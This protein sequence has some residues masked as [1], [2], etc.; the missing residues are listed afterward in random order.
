D[1][2]FTLNVTPSGGSAIASD[3]LKVSV[4]ATA[5]VP[6]LESDASGPVAPSTAVNLKWTIENFV[7]G[8]TAQVSADADPGDAT[9]TF[10]GQDVTPG[11]DGSGTLAVT[12]TKGGDFSF[13]LSVTPSGGTAVD[14]DP[15]KLTISGGTATAEW[16]VET[17]HLG[18]T[19]PM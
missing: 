12:P 16:G 6:H 18:D 8:M 10:G 2:N 17:V 7:A 13:K 5:P 15:L 9:F 1:F 11:A 14:S 19:A 3:P 4:Q